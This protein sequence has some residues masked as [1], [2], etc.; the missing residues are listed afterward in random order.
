YLSYFPC[1]L[2]LFIFMQTRTLAKMLGFRVS[3]ASSDRDRRGLK[4]NR[5][6][7]KKK[8]KK[9][10]LQKPSR[11]QEAHDNGVASVVDGA[12]NIWVEKHGKNPSAVRNGQLQSSSRRS[13]VVAGRVVG[14][15]REH[16]RHA[17][18]DPRGHHD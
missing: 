4:I 15:P 8:E 1:S 5:K 18:V 16:G 12:V 10:N 6:K 17:A 9:N 2:S 7:R 13:L 3:V 11:S 14:E